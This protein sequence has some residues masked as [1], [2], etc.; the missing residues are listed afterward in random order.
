MSGAAEETTLTGDISVSKTGMEEATV[1]VIVR[2]S[3]VYDRSNS[4]RDKLN[5]S[6]TV[7]VIVR[8]A[9]LVR[10]QHLVPYLEADK[11]ST[12]DE[13]CFPHCSSET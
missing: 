12:R 4:C 6:E 9:P 13:C 10:L 5:V 7:C 2:I 1:R 3:Y 8:I 11:N